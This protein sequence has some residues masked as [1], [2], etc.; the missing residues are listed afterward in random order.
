MKITHF[1]AIAALAIGTV[2]AAHAD[3]ITG[4]FSEGG[5]QDSFTQNTL[6]F[7]PQTAVVS[8][9]LGGTFA[10]YLTFGNPIAFI[11]GTVPYAQGQNTAP[12]GLPPLFSTTENGET[13]DFFLTSYDASY[14]T[15]GTSG[16]A[17]GNTCLLV[18]GAGYFTGTGVVDYTNT[19]GTI[20]FTSSYVSGG[21]PVGTV[22]TFQANTSA[23]APAVPEPASL[24]LFGTGL[25]GVVGFARRRFNV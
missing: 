25:L 6:N 10:T 1:A 14:V 3:S 24:A 19:P 20:Q 5:G 9:S 21:S 16:C 15:N 12:P 2:G 8:G 4:F 7:S 23:I 13:F 11:A 18:G 17:T 22:T